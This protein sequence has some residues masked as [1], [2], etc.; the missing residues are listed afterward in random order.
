[1]QPETRAQRT[2]LATVEAQISKLRQG[3]ARLLDS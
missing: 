2:P 3:V 1:L